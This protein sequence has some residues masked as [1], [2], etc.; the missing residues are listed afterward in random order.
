MET[1]GLRYF[2][3][4]GPRQNPNGVYAAAIPLF[5]DKMQQGGEI[6]VNGDGTQ[7]RDFTYV[8][9]AVLANLLSLSAT[10]NHASG[11]V[12]QR[13][14]R[15]KPHIERVLSALENRIEGPR[16]SAQAHCALRP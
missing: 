5:L 2:N 7:T 14:L 8:R 1:I 11:K 4:F 15:Q 12:L 13:R 3:V 9:N 16:R 10:K 6:V